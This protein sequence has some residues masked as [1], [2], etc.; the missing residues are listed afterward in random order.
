MSGDY[1]FTAPGITQPGVAFGSLLSSQAPFVPT[2]QIAPTYQANQAMQ[3][4]QAL[5]SSQT[6]QAEP[7]Y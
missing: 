5:Q 1:V 4:T 3:T 2:Q 6:Q 7:V